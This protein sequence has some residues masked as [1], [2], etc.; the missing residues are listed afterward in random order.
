MRSAILVSFLAVLVASTVV[1]AQPP[2]RKLTRITETHSNELSVLILGSGAP[3]FNPNRSRPSALVQYGTSNILVDMGLGTERRLREENIQLG[4]ITAF[5]L[6]HHH[7][8]HNAE[9][10]ALLVA[11]KVRGG[12]IKIF[13]PPGTER[14]VRFLLDFY[15]EDIAYR[16]Q[17]KGQALKTLL[18]VSVRDL[19]GGESFSLEGLTVRTTQVPHSIHTIAY[20]FDTPEGSIV[21]SGDLTYSENLIELA[22]GA[23]LLVIDSGN[24]PTAGAKEATSREQTQR[25]E[26]RRRAD[27][28][29]EQAH[30]TLEQV[31]EM[32][33]RAGVSCLV[34]THITVPN[35]DEGAVR[36]RVG[37]IFKGN[38][39]LAADGLKLTAREK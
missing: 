9:L 12:E 39:V 31:A 23:D 13:G 8:D 6:T 36:K 27:P 30:A 7:I 19:V 14:Y 24:L 29:R 11:S 33:Q 20:R 37:K 34:L 3:P 25:Q 35:V 4:Q 17:K 21:I 10:P 2:A 22:Q 5:F 1:L 26:S 16:T 32:G 38:V 18:Q 15:T 28:D